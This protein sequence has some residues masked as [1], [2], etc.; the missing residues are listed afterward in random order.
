MSEVLTNLKANIQE[1]LTKRTQPDAACGYDNT[2]G[3]TPQFE[4][5]E[6]EDTTG[7]GAANSQVHLTIPRKRIFC[8]GDNNGH[9]YGS[10]LAFLHFQ[11]GS[12]QLPGLL[13]S[14]DQIKAF[15]FATINGPGIG[16]QVGVIEFTRPIQDFFLSFLNIGAGNSMIFMTCDD[17][18]PYV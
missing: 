14:T 11:P 16:G 8:M 7:N 1:A 4:F 3:T 9:H 2:Q 5:L 13:S 6:I 12:E 17:W 10:A 15:Q 18:I